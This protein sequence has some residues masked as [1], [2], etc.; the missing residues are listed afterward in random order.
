MNVVTLGLFLSWRYGIEIQRKND[1]EK[2]SGGPKKEKQ[3]SINF[4]LT[5]FLF[6]D[7]SVFGVTMGYYLVAMTKERDLSKKKA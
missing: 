2:L 6:V 1:K 5:S 7:H 4:L 3:F